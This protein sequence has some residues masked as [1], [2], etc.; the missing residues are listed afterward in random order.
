MS[1]NRPDDIQPEEDPSRED[2]SEED[3][4]RFSRPTVRR[5]QDCGCEVFEDADVCPG[6]HAFVWDGAATER[7]GKPRIARFTFVLFAI[8][9]ILTLTGILAVIVR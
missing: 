3:M 6:C 8:V 9:L 2:P 1:A 7:P 4:D 5:C